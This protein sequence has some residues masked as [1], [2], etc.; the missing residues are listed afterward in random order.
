MRVA[1]IDYSSTAIHIALVNPDDST[2][3]QLYHF[4]L[5]ASPDKAFDR[6]RMVGERMPG[7]ANSFWDD[8]LAVGIEAPRGKFTAATYRV[9]G[10]VLSMIPLRVLVE[11]FSP[12]VWRNAVKLNGGCS[13]EAIFERATELLGRRPV[14]QDAADAYCIALATIRKLEAQ[15]GERAA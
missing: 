5:E 11:D 4:P 1:G 8:V 13:K 2:D 14:S 10:A 9:Q 12:K 7:R 15:H 6:T 3:A